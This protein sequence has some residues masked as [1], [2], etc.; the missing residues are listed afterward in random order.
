MKTETANPFRPQAGPQEKFLKSDADIAIYGGSAGSGKSFAL[1]L[2]PLYDTDNSG[3]RAVIFRRT[4]PMLRQPGGIVDTSHQVFPL[5][6]AQFNQSLLEWQ[7][8]TGAVVKFAGME[9]EADRFGWQGAQIAVI[10]FDEIQEFTENQFWFMVSRNRSMSGARCR[11]RG[12]CNP[13]CDSWLRNFLSWWIDDATGLPIAERSGVLRWFI[14]D[15][16]EL[17][18]ADSREEL[19]RKFGPDYQP[20]SVTFVSARVTDNKIL[21]S[22]DPG[23]VSNLKALPLVERERLLNG[24]WNVRASAGNYFRREWFS[25]IDCVPPGV[26]IVAR[27]RYWDRAATEKRPGND[28]DATVG[29]RLAKDTRGVYY[30]EHVLK[31]FATPHAVEQAMVNC[32]QVDGR[33]TTIGFMQDPGSAGKN[34]AQATTRALDG[35]D[36]RFATATGD[37]ETRAKPVSAQCE[38][39][40]VKLIRGPWNEEFLRELESFPVGKRDDAVDAFSGAHGLLS[41]NS[42]AFS[43]A[44]ELGSGGSEIDNWLMPP[45]DEFVFPDPQKFEM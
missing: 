40:N 6:G 5:L 7:F 37:K 29:L 39:G 28:P 21:L 10:G 26:Q 13:S 8:K 16:D 19:V 35:F 45:G 9:L 23:Y 22:K 43:S 12:T 24:N 41:S 20:K 34:E 15:G 36:V 42:G 30:V 38:A 33:P 4:V 25:V 18:W 32:A 31:M 27:V 17:F 3:F 44:S 2:E 1:L 11:I 14:R